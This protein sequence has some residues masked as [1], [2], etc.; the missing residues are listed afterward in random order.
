MAQRIDGYGPERAEK[1][2]GRLDGVIDGMIQH[3]KVFDHQK[4]SAED[5]KKVEGYKNSAGVVVRG[6]NVVLECHIA[7]GK[8]AAQRRALEKDT[9]RRKRA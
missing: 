1:D 9:P 8:T 5:T 7:A 3:M 2:I 6:V 4:V